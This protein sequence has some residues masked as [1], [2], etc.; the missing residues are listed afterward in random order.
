MSC[1]FPV[2]VLDLGAQDVRGTLA[3]AAAADVL[4]FGR[5]WI[6]EH[7]DEGAPHANPTLLAALVAQGT[8][9][10][11]VGPS[12]VLLRYRTAL[13][14]AHDATLLE[15]L[16]PG[17]VDFGV[18]SA[19]APSPQAA[20]LGDGLPDDDDA[21]AAR[22]LEFLA[23]LRRETALVPLPA[24]APAPDAAPAGPPPVWLS[25][26]SH[27]RARFAAA[28]GVGFASS[29]FHTSVP[30]SPDVFARYRDAFVPRPELP[31]PVTALAVSVLCA[32][33]A[34][35]VRVYDDVYQRLFG[36]EQTVVGTA[37]QCAEQLAALQRATGA[38]ELV[39]AP[40]QHTAAEAVR[41]LRALAAALGLPTP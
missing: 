22:T 37:A 39:L 11:R 8:R 18:A 7:H 10:L 2:G 32:E 34:A 15:A 19:R 4:G 30:V 41:G 20:A 17:R 27:A 9:A 24:P 5:F 36:Y 6:T 12:G 3:V 25:G 26:N 21:L 13:A 35:E 28:A 31:A 40:R 14:L 29:S 33:S 38:D 1:S 16:F 23:I